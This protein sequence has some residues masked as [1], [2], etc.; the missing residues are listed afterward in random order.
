[1]PNP[2]PRLRRKPPFVL[3]EDK[4][5]VLGFNDEVGRRHPRYLHVDKILPE[6]FVGD[7]NAPVVMLGNNPG[8][9][10]KGLRSKRD[11]TFMRR[12]RDNLCHKPTDYPFVFLAPDFD[13]PGKRWWK[14]KLG[15]L[16]KCL[17]EAKVAQTVFA[18]EYFPYPSRKYGHRKL[19]LR[20]QQYSFDPVSRAMKRRAFVFLMR[21][22]RRWKKAVE[23]LADY[24]RLILL[25]SPRQPRITKKTPHIEEVVQAV[26]DWLS[27]TASP[28]RAAG[29]AKVF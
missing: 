17:G 27:S 7:P 23:C 10:K 19:R 3:P 12:M 24:D 28:R 16:V 14:R 20:C 8:F 26:I 11:A 6:A 13:G 2:W 22:E 18:V 1:M 15:Y 25:N 9:T 5:A 4:A 21:G 29:Q